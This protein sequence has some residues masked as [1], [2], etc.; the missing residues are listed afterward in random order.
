[1]STDTVPSP[2]P[3]PAPMAAGLPPSASA[4]DA[5]ADLR[6]ALRGGLTLPGEPAWDAARQAWNLAVEQRPVA[7]VDAADADDVQAVVRFAS[8]HG[9]QVTMQSTGHGAATLPPLA[10]TVLVRTRAMAEVTVDPVRRRARVGAGTHVG[11][12]VAS[13]AA[14]GLAFTAGSSP[15]V[16]VVGYTLGG[17]VGWLA[18]SHGLAC[19]QLVAAEVVTADGER[20]RVDADHDAELFW[21][22]RGGGGAF[23]AVTAL[24]VAL[25]PITEVHAGALSWPLEHAADVLHAWRVWTHEVP[26]R[27]TSIARILRYPPLPDLPPELRG[28]AFVRIEA[29]FLDD[30]VEAD[31][32]LRPLR[33]LRPDTDTFATIAAPALGQLHGDP[34]HPVPSLGDHRLLAE[35]PAA[36]VDAILEL[37]GPDRS[38]PLLAVD[39]R[40]LGGASGATAP[41]HGVLDRIDAAFA[42]FTVGVP[43]APDMAAAIGGSMEAL[44][45]AVAPWDA[46]RSYLNFAEQPAAPAQLFGG[47]GAARLREV[48]TAYDPMDRFVSNHAVR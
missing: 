17:G 46:G 14:H 11:E 44:G 36:A 35:L 5:L 26:D 43:V 20:R 24:E 23:A 15:D 12:L 32:W 6:G 13:A 25:H 48:K 31:R 7:V 34:E 8:T 47:D 19:N 1:M 3:R 22:L 39:L 28:Q 18:R 45:A 2:P 21:A 40:H 10:D 42:L 4:A 27:V 38:S 9:L 41:G 29:S 33:A 37:V 30:E 16:G